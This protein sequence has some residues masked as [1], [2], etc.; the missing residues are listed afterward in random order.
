MNCYS[1]RE[2]PPESWWRNW[3]WTS[4]RNN[5]KL[6]KIYKATVLIY[7]AT[8]IMWLWSLREGKS[9]KWSQNPCR[10]S[11]WRYLLDWNLNRVW[12]FHNEYTRVFRSSGGPCQ[13]LILK[14]F[15][16]FKQKQK[17]S[18]WRNGDWILGR[19]KYQEIYWAEHYRVQ[20]IIEKNSRILHKSPIEALVKYAVCSVRIQKNNKYIF[21]NWIA[22]H[23][24][25]NNL[26]FQTH[27]QEN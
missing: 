6:D 14:W 7:W 8:S 22:L 21:K 19:R 25:Q 2:L 10:L 24:N 5:Y 3:H 27:F 16:N 26:F 15:R 1:I 11:F 13:Y 23:Q 9:L 17:Q 18:S 12:K 20:N 4:H